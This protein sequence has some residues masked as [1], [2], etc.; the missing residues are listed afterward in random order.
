[1]EQV[2]KPAI[3][4]APRVDFANDGAGRRVD[5]Y[6]GC[7]R[8]VESEPYDRQLHVAARIV[9]IGIGRSQTINTNEA[10]AG[11]EF[12]DGSHNIGGGQ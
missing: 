3:E 11:N 7:S 9:P 1:M 5:V 6:P 2:E 12:C 10:P 8:V 4:P